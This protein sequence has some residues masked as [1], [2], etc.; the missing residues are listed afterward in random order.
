MKLYLVR[1]GE[2]TYNIDGII[3]PLGSELSEKGKEQAK[4][5]A[6]RFK[7]IPV[8][9]IISSPLKRA[10]QTAEIIERVIQKEVIYTDLL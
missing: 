5:L 6:A 1:H 2:S 3:Q 10:K 4:F 9:I 7:N 8:D